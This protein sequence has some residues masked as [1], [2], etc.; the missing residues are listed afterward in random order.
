MIIANVL[1]A[2]VSAVMA[3]D[4]YRENNKVAFYLSAFAVLINLAAVWALSV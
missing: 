4:S 3:Y 2:I 1:C